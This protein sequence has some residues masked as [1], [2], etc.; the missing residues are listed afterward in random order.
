MN[1]F[2]S[3]YSRC[4]RCGKKTAAGLKKTDLRL[5]IWEYRCGNCKNVCWIDR[6]H[7]Y[8]LITLLLA[9]VF[10]FAVFAAYLHQAYLL[11]SIP[12]L[13]SI[14]FLAHRYCPRYKKIP[15]SDTSGVG[16][17]CYTERLPEE[18]VAGQIENGVFVHKEE[19]LTTVADFD[20]F[21]VLRPLP[22]SFL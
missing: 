1:L 4:P 14:P 21:P 13:A 10:L 18:S 11:L 9:A 12:I 20:F 16:P 3:R 8:N 7:S 2:F 17:S 6:A 15:F 22:R 5:G 19:S